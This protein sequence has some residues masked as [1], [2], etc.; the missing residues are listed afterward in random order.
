MATVKKIETSSSVIV[1]LIFVVRITRAFSTV[2]E[3]DSF[4]RSVN[5]I[6]PIPKR[7]FAKLVD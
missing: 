6:C 1:P 3:A 7:G 2:K 4:L 5:K